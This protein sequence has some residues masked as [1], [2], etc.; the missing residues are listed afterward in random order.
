MSV[1]DAK[2]DRIRITVKANAGIINRL[3]KRG[4][5]TMA[6]KMTR[7]MEW[8]S[9][10]MLYAYNVAKTD[11]VEALEKDIR[12]RGF[13]RAPLTY[14]EKELNEFWHELSKNLYS[15]MMTVT[16]MAL[17]DSFGYGKKR[18][19]AFKEK[20]DKITETAN[21][22]DYLG[23]HYVTLA[24]YAEYL[25]EECDLGIDTERVAIAQESYDEKSES[26]HAANIEE[27]LKV[28]RDG[29]YEDASEFLEGKLM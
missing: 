3:K 9:Q 13:L 17:H 24:D 16:C 11:G 5:D 21:N 2:W 29:G 6:K 20:F 22:L 19:K 4:K 12:L 23:D 8:R 14:T 1:S 27:V 10:G 15:T 28:L 25:N 26:Y 18:I 7:E